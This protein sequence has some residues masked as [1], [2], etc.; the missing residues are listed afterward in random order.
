MESEGQIV[1]QV[2]SRQAPRLLNHAVKPLQPDSLEPVGGARYLSGDEA[3]AYPNP[4]PPDLTQLRRQLS[5]YIDGL[6]E[7]RLIG[8]DAAVSRHPWLLHLQ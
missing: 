1:N 4:N 2:T 8:E 6:M 3:Q 7:C 5:P